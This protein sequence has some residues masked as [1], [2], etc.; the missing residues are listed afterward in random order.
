MNFEKTNYNITNVSPEELAKYYNI[1]EQSFLNNKNKESFFVVKYLDLGVKTVKLE[2]YTQQFLPVIE[3]NFAY[4]IKDHSDKYDITFRLWQDDI[5]NYITDFVSNAESIFISPELKPVIKL[6]IKDNALSAYNHKTNTFY[7]AVNNLTK[8]F[9][10]KNGHIFFDLISEMVKT[11]NSA[12]V[13]GACVGVEN[14]GVLICGRGGRGKSTLAV[15]SLLDNFEYIAD[16]YLILNKTDKLYAHPVY[17]IVILAPHMYEKM[18][19][20]KAEF[21]WDNYNNTKYVFDISAHHDRFVKKIPVKTVIFP[22]I[23]AD[24]TVP[25]IEP[26][27]KG[28]AITQL[29]YST[30]YQMGEQKNNDFMKKLISFVSDLDFYQINL[31]PDLKANVKALKNFIKERSSKNV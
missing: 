10:S 9:V 28:R 4:C 22:E 1:I 3:K 13:H 16:D 11:P 24:S 14:E 21:L 29:I 2:I 15:S 6:F 17:S 19:D 30:A 31:S 12:L 7:F 27:N 20:L 8:G 5:T 18:K 23:S 26:V 25:S